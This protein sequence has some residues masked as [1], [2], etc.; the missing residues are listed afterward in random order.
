MNTATFFCRQA[1]AEDAAS[2]REIV[3]EAMTELQRPFL[4]DDQL[5]ASREI[6]GLDLQ[7]VEDGTYFLVETAE[8]QVAG[9]GGWSRRAALFGAGHTPDRDLR[10][11][12]PTVDA[13]RIRAVYTNPSFARQGVGRMVLDRCEAEAA[14]AGFRKVELVA[15]LAGHK[16]FCHC[17]YRV[18]EHKTEV[19]GGVPI[20]LL[21][22]GKDLLQHSG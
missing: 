12:D 8:R 4:D 9:C 10:L 18:I 20:P 11:L 13:A 17:G 3:E 15:T 6:M 7:L 14:A 19:R 5:R 22:M 16:L 2:L 1:R 21:Q